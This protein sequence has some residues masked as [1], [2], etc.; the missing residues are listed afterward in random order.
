M[1][2]KH[3]ALVSLFATTV[4]HDLFFKESQILSEVMAQMLKH[5]IPF[6]PVHDA[7]YLALSQVEKGR[8]IIE[9][10]F[11]GMTGIDGLVRVKSEVEK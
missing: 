10:L 6:L 1:D 11:L 9:G 7:L 2:A 5:S 4:G 3:P 8:R